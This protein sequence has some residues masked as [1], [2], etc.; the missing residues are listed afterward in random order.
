MKNNQCRSSPL[1]THEPRNQIYVKKRAWISR[2]SRHI[3]I[4]DSTSRL[5][6]AAIVSTLLLNC[7]K[8]IQLSETQ[9]PFRLLHICLHQQH[10][11]QYHLRL[12]HAVTTTSI[13]RRQ[14]FSVTMR[15][16]ITGIKNIM[17]IATRL[18]TKHSQAGSRPRGKMLVRQASDKCFLTLLAKK[19][20][21]DV[22]KLDEHWW[23]LRLKRK[24]EKVTCFNK[25]QTEDEIHINNT[26]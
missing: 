16:Y 7:Y 2:I 15:A 9:F 12:L 3:C 1:W 8:R 11:C 17:F 22:F 25:V 20:Q 21:F 4:C 19:L 26:N 6:W 5:T 14:L 24:G 10:I 23:K 18:V 13:T